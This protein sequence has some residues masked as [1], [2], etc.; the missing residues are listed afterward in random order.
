MAVT[1]CFVFVLAVILAFPRFIV[2]RTVVHDVHFNEDD[3]LGLLLQPLFVD[4]SGFVHVVIVKWNRNSIFLCL[5]L[6]CGDV[7]SNLFH[8][9]FVK[10][11]SWM[12]IKLYVV[13]R[14]TSGFT[15][16]VIH[17]CRI[18]FTMKWSRIHQ[19]T[20]GTAQYV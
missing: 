12:M 11:M 18:L 5:L 15:S 14:V 8:V 4:Y 20:A 9:P 1:C 7:Q 13:T 2:T 6:L 16:R 10:L 19:K 3:P 17:P